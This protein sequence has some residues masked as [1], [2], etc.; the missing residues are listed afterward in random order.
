M[1]R[2]RSKRQHASAPSVPTR[3]LFVE[4]FEQRTLLA[5]VETP[6]S[7]AL[8]FGPDFER[9]DP[10]GDFQ[11]R[12]EPELLGAAMLPDGTLR[13]V[14]DNVSVNPSPLTVLDVNSRGE[15]IRQLSLPDS[16]H[17]HP[18]SLGESVS[19]SPNGQWVAIGNEVFQIDGAGAAQII[20]RPDDIPLGAQLAGRVADNGRVIISA[21]G[22][23][24][25]W[26]AANG[27]K[28]LDSLFAGNPDA[29]S[30]QLETEANAIAVNGNTVS[31]NGNTVVGDSGL[32]GDFGHATV[33]DDFGPHALPD[34]GRH[35][36]VPADGRDHF[37]RSLPTAFSARGSTVR[38]PRGPRRTCR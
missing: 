7:V 4:Q 24:Y 21:L 18:F 27:L 31:G 26:D 36:R 10:C 30:I 17:L 29:N 8:P 37:A 34:L 11:C 6:V 5:G 38:A 9:F 3:R 15:I 14:A 13:L 20:P 33:W 19:I 16:M 23:S 28:R 22:K 35:L 2:R 32:N 25:V 1:R 12:N